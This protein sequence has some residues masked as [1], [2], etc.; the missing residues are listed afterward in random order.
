[1]K[2]FF[3]MTL[4]TFVGV[5]LFTVICTGLL[6]ILLGTVASLSDVPTTT[7][8]NTVFHLELSGTLTERGADDVQTALLSRL[9]MSSSS[10]GLNDV[11]TAIDNAEQD[12]HIKGIYLDFGTLS[13]SPAS[14]NELRQALE[15]F[16]SSGKFVIAYADYY[17]NGT[18]YLASTADKIFLNPKGMLELTGMSFSTIFFK[19]ALDKLGVEMQVFKVGT[20]KSAVEPFTNTSMSAANRLQMETIVQSIWKQTCNAIAQCRHIE[21]AV[22]DRFANEGIFMQEPELAVQYGLIDSLLYRDNIK[23]ALQTYVTEN[24]HTIKLSQMKHIV[25]KQKY[26][27]DK[28]AVVYAVGSIDDESSLDGIKSEKLAKQLTDLSTDSMI[29][30]VVLRINSPGGSAYGSEQLWH[31]AEVLKAKKPLVVSMGDYAASGGYY[32]ACNA[33]VIVAH[34]NTLTGSIG[35]FGLLPNTKPL[36][37]KIGLSFDGVKT[38][39]FSNLGTTSRPATEAEK[40]LIQRNIERGYALFVKRCADGR[41]LSVDSIKTI[42]E[43][44]VW[45]GIDALQLGLVD[46]LGNLQ[47]AITIAAQRAHLEADAYAIKTYPPK[48]GVMDQL[49]EIFGS[50]VLQTEWLKSNL[51]ENYHYLRL[52]QQ[53]QAMQGVQAL[54][55][56][57]CDIR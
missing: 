51:G 6:F 50:N 19:S 44:R 30:A 34:P 15:R 41:G 28:I 37:D 22:I 55:P 25:P 53:A 14:L 36:T 12:S 26:M 18:Y 21:P 29:K 9:S 38:N 49:Q 42:A 35:I 13:A 20:F 48:K 10:I 32:M 4:A 46:T 16:K 57:V 23:D 40:L 2:K 52:L 31:A 11:L 54:M 45:T 39:K 3:K 7:K 1:M 24:H 17:T 43:G 8:D 33:D 5:F 27:A 56:F 47:T